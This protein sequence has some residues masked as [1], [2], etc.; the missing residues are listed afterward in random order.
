M[1]VSMDTGLRATSNYR[2]WTVCQVTPQSKPFMSQ[3]Q[4][5]V[6]QP[7]LV[8]LAPKLICPWQSVE[9]SI[10]AVA[11]LYNTILSVTD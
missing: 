11:V 7:C 2:F 3:D 4:N 1:L 10:S 9:D 5:K 6:T 8:Q